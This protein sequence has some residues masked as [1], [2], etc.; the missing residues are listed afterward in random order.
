MGGLQ[1][2]CEVI[3]VILA[4]I[5]VLIVLV[6]YML[7]FFMKILGEYLIKVGKLICKEVEDKECFKLVIFYIVLGDFYLMVCKDVG[8]FYVCLD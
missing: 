1:V 5:K 2:L 3:E 7:V 8:G 6:Q 4:D